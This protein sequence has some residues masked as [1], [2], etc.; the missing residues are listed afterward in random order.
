[1]KT[2]YISSF[3]SCE[4]S[5]SDVA[6]DHIYLDI[7]M[8]CKWHMYRATTFIIITMYKTAA[9]LNHPPF[10]GYQ[11]FFSLP[12][13]DTDY[14][15]PPTAK[16]NK[17]WGYTY[18]SPHTIMIWHLSM[19]TMSALHPITS[20]TKCNLQQFL[21]IWYLTILPAYLVSPLSVLLGIWQTTK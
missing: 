6:T 9:G 8:W 12:E 1:M 16:V 3:F 4:T 21:Y 14:S 18:I 15:P 2:N 17:T 5:S 11:V 13:C 19:G 10:H 20:T 7:I